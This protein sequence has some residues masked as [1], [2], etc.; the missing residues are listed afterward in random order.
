M[1]RIHYSAVAIAVASSLLSV[2]PFSIAEDLSQKNAK[3][4]EEI[5]ASL[6]TQQD[7][8]VQWNGY[9][10]SGFNSN[11]SG[12]ASDNTTIQAPNSGGFYRLGGAESNYAAWNLNRKFTVGDAWAKAYFGLAYEDR[13]ARRWL[14]DTKNDT[15]FMD[16]AYVEMG[17]LDFAPDATFWAGRVNY[18]YDIHILDSKFYEIRS[19]GIGVKGLDM[20]G[21]K[22]DLFVVAHDSDSD[23]TY[24]DE[25]GT[26][27]TY[28]DGAKPRTHTLG[29]EYKK[30]NWWFAASVQ[31]NSNDESFQ[32][33]K[34]IDGVSGTYDADA[35]T[36]G[37]QIMVNYKQD[38][39]FGLTNGTTKYVAQYG[40]GLS[41]AYLGR[42]GD[43]NQSNKD[44]QSYRFFI[45]GL[46]Q[47]GKWDLN[48][49]A[50]IQQKDDVDFK[51]SKNSWWTIGAR[52]VYYVTE[53]FAMQFEA[54]YTR[55][56]YESDTQKEEGGLTTLTIAPTL[57]LKS[58]FMNRPEIRFFATY[59]NYTGDY[60]A[61][62]LDGYDSDDRNVFTFG[63]QAEVWF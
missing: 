54:G 3:A 2:S 60:T 5:K 30:D 33:T 49:V 9:F 6:A 44:G 62:S 15:I 53:N 16:K 48:T 57:K 29:A 41:A 58:A 45:D 55:S 38:S 28:S 40:N 27:V 19:P 18:G 21:G 63:A 47:M 1:K 13:E 23:T 32:V 43:T 7:E 17:N 39:Y 36:F 34:N 56:N 22:V 4:I 14:F 51:G 59:G 52:P 25:S 10:R 8:A 46:A 35:A 37:S 20:A 50:L 61:D 26:T 11:S 31:T 24:T 12:S 42:I